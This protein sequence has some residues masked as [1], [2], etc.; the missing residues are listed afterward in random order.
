LRD[1]LGSFRLRLYAFCLTA[2]L[3]GSIPVLAAEVKYS[4]DFDQCIDDSG[5]SYPAMSDCFAK[6]T[7]AWDVKLN[8]N[9]KAV[10]ATLAP[11]RKKALLDAERAW[12][13]SRDAQ[14]KL[15]TD[16]NGGEEAQLA[17][18]ECF[19][20]QTAERAQELAAMLPAGSAPVEQA[21]AAPGPAPAPPSPVQ[22]PAVAPARPAEPLVQST[23]TALDGLGLAITTAKAGV[24]HIPGA[25][26][27][28]DVDTVEAMMDLVERHEGETAIAAKSPAFA[29][30]LRLYQGG[31]TPMPD[32]ADAGCVLVPAGSRI[33]VGLVHSQGVAEV[34]ALDDDGSVVSGVTL[35]SMLKH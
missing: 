22:Q 14:C 34:K 18:R 33:A 15:A 25:I 35:L 9:Y 17:G 1:F 7:A 16:P 8:A 4:A 20:K 24:G 32:L 5:G 31:P 10:M 13:R 29:D 3:L 21:A 11:D 28:P 30:N 2:A 27:C 23:R 6:E 12:L 26:V 19:M